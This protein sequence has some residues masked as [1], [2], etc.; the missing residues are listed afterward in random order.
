M[1]HKEKIKDIMAFLFILFG[2]MDFVLRLMNMSPD[3]ILEKWDFIN[4]TDYGAH[5]TMMHA[6]LKTEV[7]DEYCAKWGVL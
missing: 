2:E 6:N 1:T 4:N 7:F 5:R 3:Y